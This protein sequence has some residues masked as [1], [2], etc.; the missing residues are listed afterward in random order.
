MTTNNDMEKRVMAGVAA[1]YVARKFSSR[2]ALKTYALL[3]SALGIAAFTSVPQ[4][5]TN[6]IHIESYGLPAMGAFFISA[7]TRTSLLVQAALV[8]GF[9]TALSLMKEAVL[10]GETRNFA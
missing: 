6:F 8:V 9:I 1:I 7:V 3:A 2:R 10:R 4:V 5:L